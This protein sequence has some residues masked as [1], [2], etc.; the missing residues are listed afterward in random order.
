MVRVAIAQP[1]TAPEA[2]ASSATVR[3]TSADVR[4]IFI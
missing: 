3:Y 4:K 2:Q 1:E